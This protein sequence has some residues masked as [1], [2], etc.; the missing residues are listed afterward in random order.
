MML[1]SAG[2]N[3]I[4]LT[5]IQAGYL[6]NQAT[7]PTESKSLPMR[8]SVN[9]PGWPEGR[10][11]LKVFGNEDGLRSGY[12]SCLTF[13]QRGYLW[14]GTDDGAAF[15]DGQTWTPVNMPNRTISNWILAMLATQ[16][17]SLWF[18]RS[19]DGLSRLHNGAWTTYTPK[20]SGI[21]SQSVYCLYESTTPD[22]KSC[23][24]IGTDQGLARFLD[25]QWTVF[26]TQNSGLAGN[27]IQC[28]YESTLP[29]KP[30]VLWVGTET[31]L[32]RI[33]RFHDIQPT[34]SP[35]GTGSGWTNFTT[36]NSKLPGDRVIKVLDTI[37]PDGQWNFWIVTYHGLVLIEPVSAPSPA[38]MMPS[39]EP[40]DTRWLV[41]TTQNMLPPGMDVMS[42]T[43]TRS[44]TGKRVVWI[45]ADLGLVRLTEKPGA[46]ATGIDRFTRD[47]YTVHNSNL[48][49]DGI[50]QIL[51]TPS[52]TGNPMLWIAT[53]GGGVAC[54][55]EDWWTTFDTDYPGLP[56]NLIDS[57]LETTSAAGNPVLWVGTDENGLVRYEAGKVINFDPKN[58]PLPDISITCLLETVS[59]A[60]RPAVWIGTKGN[61]VILLE[62]PT[63][64]SAEGPNPGDFSWT[65]FDLNTFGL[66]PGIINDLM[67]VTLPSGQRV[68][69]VASDGGLARYE[70]GKWTIFPI[71]KTK[72]LPA[73]PMTVTQT[74]RGSTSPVLWIGTYGGGL[75]RLEETGNPQLEGEQ[76]YTATSF[77]PA[78]SKLPNGFVM[79]L[80]Q[81]VSAASHQI[82]W[83]GTSYAGVVRVDLTQP[84]TP[85]L[86]LN[87]TSTPAMPDNTVYEILEDPAHRVYFLTNNGVAQLTERQSSSGNGLE[88]SML[89]F[90]T[91]DGLPINSCNSIAGM[92]DHLGRIWVGTIKG[93]ARFD[94]ASR[95]EDHTPKPLLISQ[96]W[97]N[98][99]PFG[100]REKPSVQPVLGLGDQSLDGVRLTYD[101]NHLVFEYRLVSFF[102]P[103]ET[104]Y[105]TQLIGLDAAPSEWSPDTKKEYPALGEGRY[106]F[107]VWGRDASGNVTGPRELSFFIKPAPWRTWWAYGVYTCL[108]VGLGYG[109]LRWRIKTLQRQNLQLEEKVKLRTQELSEKN[110]QLDHK[111]A[112]LAQKN[113]E[114]A[115]SKD[116]LIKSYQQAEQIFSAL[117][118]VLPGTE[119]D[120]KY[121]LDKKIGAGGFGA[122]YQGTH[123]A[124]KRQVA[125]KVFR[126]ASVNATNESL[127]RFKLEAVST[128]RVNHP[129]AVAVLDSGVSTGGIA[130][131]VME[132]LQ[133]KSLNQ[134]LGTHRVLSPL[135]CA[136]IVIPV[137]NVLAKAHSLGIVHRD[138]KPDN[139]FLHQS[140]D[141]EIVKVVDFGIAKLVGDTEEIE[142][143]NLTGTHNLIG[144][145]DYM[146]PERLNHKPY[147]GRADVYSVGVMAYQM[148]VGKPPFHSDSGFV[149][150]IL[151]HMTKNPDP[152]RSINPSIPEAVDR[153]VL[154]ALE[155]N[156][157]ARPTAQEFACELATAVGTTV[158]ALSVTRLERNRLET[159]GKMILGNIPSTK[160]NDAPTMIESDRSTTAIAF[161]NRTTVEES[162]PV[163]VGNTSDET[164][165]S[166][167]T[168]IDNASPPRVEEKN[169]DLP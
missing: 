39:R 71:E 65:I 55:R 144:T 74:S 167:L 28:V 165:D 146:S 108:L 138:I 43:E 62:E 143:Q 9:P 50:N 111:V 99:Q 26:T 42:V 58:S 29:G 60:G 4:G 119:L 147:D 83:I 66:S 3:W 102:K 77:T 23:L 131:L 103:S 94:P 109:S 68:L 11:F 107:R 163:F 73:T 69:W 32:S 114:L 168:M 76:A 17:G 57:L 161:S 84:D 2:F 104:R 158:E 141:G 91:E 67:E 13:D 130:Y 139:I 136:E 123:L 16:D 100:N 12:I 38:H 87:D 19:D 14:A 96:T 166:A 101:Q 134:L 21:P 148:L 117:A 45:G 115:Q 152:L 48:P 126:P 160:E 36:Q 70:Q 72:F 31:G 81:T 85:W 129:N 25:N 80:H 33:E 125:V 154:R 79:S 121:R 127:E 156:P 116:E 20:N 124:M 153:A 164:F 27:N 90:T 162:G 61:Q 34:P 6:S 15:Y 112:E 93:T 54:Y 47:I 40:T 157:E 24:W 7:T 140:D 56:N 149:G 97:L 53:R 22:G 1:I 110:D 75:I 52:P 89:T 35:S 41:F 95:L 82:L 44:A 150:V 86:I 145:P 105:Q 169:E 151:Q 51:Q 137:C 88:Y 78:N 49:I 159:D 92:V 37:T 18:G 8:S 155:K 135:R 122:V 120:H 128:C 98:G 10:L 46:T 59:P 106:V 132:L 142:A 5:P 133:G 113:E 63:R 30:T 64:V 118:E